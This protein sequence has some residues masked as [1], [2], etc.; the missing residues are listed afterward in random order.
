MGFWSV[1][2]LLRGGT[3][4]S[5][6]VSSVVDLQDC[7]QEF[8]HRGLRE[9]LNFD[10]VFLVA[11]AGERLQFGSIPPVAFWGGPEVPYEGRV[12]RTATAR[13]EPRPT[14]VVCPP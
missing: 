14:D 13:R 10:G 9:G 8:N 5:F 6:S 11:G 4:P 2:D 3:P 1:T 12:V 7:G